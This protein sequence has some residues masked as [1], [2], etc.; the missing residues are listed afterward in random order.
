MEL[1]RPQREAH[2]IP[3]Q[4][5]QKWRRSTFPIGD[6]AALVLK[7]L[8]QDS[9]VCM[10]SQPPRKGPASKDIQGVDTSKTRL[11]PATG[12]TAW[13]ASRSAEIASHLLGRLGGFDE[14]AGTNINHISGRREGLNRIYNHAKYKRP[15]CQA[16]IDWEAHLRR[17]IGDSAEHDCNR[18]PLTI[19]VHDRA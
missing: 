18:K 1:N 3:W 4:I 17:L 7:S 14:V 11:R 15:M 12:Y 19:G 2:H 16:V 5:D 9:L 13:D 6:L 10:F 8:G